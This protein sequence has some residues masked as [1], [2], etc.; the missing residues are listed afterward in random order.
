[1][2]DNRKLNVVYESI[3]Q[4]KSKLTAKS[5]IMLIQQ[6]GPSKFEELIYVAYFAYVLRRF[7]NDTRTSCTK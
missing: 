4:L 5:K 2:E 6:R 7:Q 1:M 3:G